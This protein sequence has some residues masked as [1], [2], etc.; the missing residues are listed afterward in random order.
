[1]HNPQRV[2]ITAVF[3]QQ[4]GPFR[5]AI[6]HLTQEAVEEV[7]SFY[8]V[9]HSMRF[10]KKQLVIRMLQDVTDEA[11]EALN[12][13]FHDIVA[14]G[15]ICRTRALPEE[16]DEAELVDLPRLMFQFNRRNLGRLRALIDVLNTAP[17]VDG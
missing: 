11:L 17:P 1:M 16:A 12:Q 14:E 13:D 15:D 7:L 8:D 4:Q 10:V 9:Y 6:N 3:L 5:T 2:I